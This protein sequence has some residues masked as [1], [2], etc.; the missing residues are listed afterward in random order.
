LEYSLELLSVL[1]V[2]ALVAG[3]VD[4]VS[5][6]GGL[7]ALP[8]LMLTGL[9]P[10]QAL[11]TNKLQAFFGKL[12]SVRYFLSQGVI[13]FARFKW[14]L[15]LCFI[16]AALG[17]LA[18]QHLPNKI[19]QQILPWMIAGAAIYLIVAPGATDKESKAKLSFNLFSLILLPVIA[20]YDGFFGPASGSFF[21]LS[22]IALAGFNSTKAVAHG[23]LILLVTNGA[24]L[25]VYMGSGQILWLLGLVMAVGQWAGAYLGSKL[26]YLKGSK[27][28]K[29]M[30]LLVC[31]LM[32]AK[33]I[34]FP[35]D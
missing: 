1:F 2:V 6:G 17:T 15:L 34:L 13:D 35:N 14:P 12:S 16:C 3:F 32:L 33:L 10:L 19:L 11:A 27:I 21:L 18:I 28:V 22:F 24:A 23:R 25:L 20:F 5:G 31:L 7:I 29:P 4:A 9:T 30:L 26:V 8:A